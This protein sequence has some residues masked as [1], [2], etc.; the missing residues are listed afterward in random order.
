MAWAYTRTHYNVRRQGQQLEAD[1]YQVFVLQKKVGPD[2]A[3][4]STA[5]ARSDWRIALIDY[6]FHREQI[7]PQLRPDSPQQEAQP[8]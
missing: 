7:N 1:L 4:A 8:K 3:T 5:S 6:T 2:D